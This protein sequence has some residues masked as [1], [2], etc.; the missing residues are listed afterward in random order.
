MS[1]NA[2][3]GIVADFAPAPF[4]PMPRPVL[5]PLTLALLA[6]LA[7]AAPGGASPGHHRDP[8]RRPLRGDRPRRRAL[9]QTEETPDDFAA[10]SGLIDDAIRVPSFAPAHVAAL[11]QR[12]QADMAGLR[13]LPWRTWS[14]DQQIDVRWVYANARRI[15]RE[16]NVERLYLHRPGAWLE[17]VANDLIAIVTYAP[18]RTDAIDGI[19]ARVPA[20]V[21]EMQSICRPTG[22]DADVGQGLVDGIVGVLK[23][24]PG[25]APATPPSLR[26]TGTGNAWPR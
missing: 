6:G 19:A 4:I 16:L 23:D 10:Q 5:L 8:R 15:D 24:D 2:G 12:L 9:V 3:E 26:S 18:A 21:A 7:P 13:A 11:T 14:V 25:R 22:V 17:T 20:L 1:P